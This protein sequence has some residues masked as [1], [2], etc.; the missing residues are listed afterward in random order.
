M[1]VTQDTTIAQNIPKLE[2]YEY[3][4]LFATKGDSE[5]LTNLRIEN[6]EAGVDIVRGA[7]SGR[8]MVAGYTFAFA[9]HFRRDQAGD[10]LLTV[11]EHEAEQGSLL[12]GDGSGSERYQNRFECIPNGVKF[13]PERKTPKP[14]ISGL[15]T[16]F[17]TGPAG[18]EIYV[19]KYG[20]IKV[21]FHWDRMGKNNEESSCWIRVAQ[22]IAGKQWGSV[23]L[24]RVGQEVVVEFL[25]GDPDRPI[26]T[27]SVYNADAMPPYTLPDEKTK[28]TFKSYSSKGGG[29][30]NELRFEDKKG[31]EQVFMQAEKDYHLRVKNDQRLT[32]LNETH[33]ITNKDTLGKI[34]GDHHLAV[35]GDQNQKVDGSV[36]LKVGMNAHQK[37]GQTLAVDAGTEIHLKSGMNLVIETGTTL[38]LKVGGNFININP[39]GI[40]IK[41]TMVMI[42]SGGSAGSGAG[43]SPA[44]PKAPQEADQAD[45]GKATQAAVSKQP[46]VA[47]T[48]SPV[49]L[50]MKQAAE[51]GAPFC[52]ICGS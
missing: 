25:E 34:G 23:F 44:A 11:I 16:A 32:V 8:T 29:G 19:D 26:V 20:R 41:G 31:S 51:S 46:P 48:Y 39:G 2:R 12:A 28:N 1:Q 50:Q 24:P 22:S 10:Y 17:V 52:E 27:G 14:V 33:T 9:E 42:N 5:H 40:F 43:C 36:S 35:T 6:E 30:F 47:L 4:G 38:T 18:E 7:G 13:R 3:P 45:A 21:Q 15:Q 37:V 49:A